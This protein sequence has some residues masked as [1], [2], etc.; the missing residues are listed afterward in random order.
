MSVKIDPKMKR[1]LGDDVFVSMALLDM[2]KAL[3]SYGI[4]APAKMRETLI[5]AQKTE[6]AHFKEVLKQI[7]TRAANVCNGFC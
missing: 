5:Q 7:G 6:L 2:D 1:V 4:K 3:T